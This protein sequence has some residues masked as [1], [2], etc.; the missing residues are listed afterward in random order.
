M[1]IQERIKK[2]IAEALPELGLKPEEVF[3]E[4]PTEIKLGDYSTN[5]AMAKAKAEKANPRVLAERMKSALNGKIENVERIEVAGPGFINFFLNKE[6]FNKEIEE[7][8]NNK[9]FGKNETQK[10][11]KVLVE[12]TNLNPFKP[13]HIGHLMNNAIGEALSRIIEWSGADLK[14]ASYG[15]DVGLHIAKTIW[16]M[17][18]FA[19]ERPK[20]D[21]LISEK[22][23]FLGRAYVFGATKYEEDE[24]IQVEIKELN[25]KVFTRSDEEVNAL[26]DWGRKVSLDNFVEIYKMLNTHVDYHFFENE[27]S[28]RAVEIVEEY[29]KKGVFEKSEGAIIFRGEKYGLHTRVFIS[30]QGIPLYEAKEIALNEKK[31]ELAPWDDSI[32]ITASEQ[33]DYFKVVMKALELI[34]P[35]IVAHSTHVPHGMLRF[36]SGKMSSRTGNIITGESLILA[37]QQMAYEKMKDRE[38]TNEE[39]NVI[40]EQVGIAA[41][42]YSILKQ[43]PGK[44][45]IYD[46]EKSL[47]FEGDSGPYL[48]YATVRGKSVLEKAKKEDI[49]SS[50][51]HP[52]EQMP[53]VVKLLARFPEIVLSAQNNLAPNHIATYLIELSS[54]FNSFYADNKIVDKHDVHSPYRVAIT[55]AFVNIMQS[56]LFL[57]GLHSPAKM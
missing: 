18:A 37:M 43:T 11:K 34:R 22:A 49:E 14:R 10:G 53:L 13:M 33:N 31:F 4:H 55:E 35:D 12:H 2:S 1:D 5:V 47:S 16:G 19:G 45:I 24:E 38:L 56:G 52:D 57:L 25:K 41:I 51:E 36:A 9:E 28:N 23:D 32:T 26:Y 39:K 46:F 6:Y 15:S 29:E 20:E 40:S 42:K 7:A 30:S 8:L 21:A 3:L 50:L 44:D 17:I 48:Q 54:S 27:V